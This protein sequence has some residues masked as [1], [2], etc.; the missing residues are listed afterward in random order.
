MADFSSIPSS[1]PS[2]V[3]CCSPTA[4]LRAEAREGAEMVSQL[5]LGETARV[6][7]RTSRWLRVA[8]LHDGYEG[9]LS[10]TQAFVLHGQVNKNWLHP[11]AQRR[12]RS[13]M[14][15]CA[16][17]SVSAAGQQLWIPAG[18]VLPPDCGSSPARGATLE[19]PFGSFR[20]VSEIPSVHHKSREG[21]TGPF[22]AISD[23]TAQLL[24]TA[25]LFLGTPYLWGGRS[26]L[27]I[28]CSG[29][30]QLLLQMQGLHPPRDASQQ[31][32]MP[33]PTARLLGS[34]V[35]T[36]A[37]GD[38]IYFS[39]DG[40]RVVHVGFYAGNGLL[41]HASGSVKLEHIDEAAHKRNTDKFAFNRRLASHIYAIQRIT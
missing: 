20:I 40:K 29:F 34:K 6:L 32:Q 11:P 2:Y 36:A 12:S 3:M 19:Y 17:E 7:E 28:D 27:G 31:I 26:T 22:P 1:Q 39:F 10:I 35:D 33:E 30:T 37:A 18:A 14:L 5:L 9:W 13:F 24:D 25:M 15:Q 21:F 16:A 38:L 8:G 41:L 23:K 4:P